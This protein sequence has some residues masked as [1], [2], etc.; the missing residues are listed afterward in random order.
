MMEAFNN[1]VLLITD[2]IFG[3]MLLLPRPVAIVLVAVGTAL[4]L[5][6]LRKWATDQDLLQRC[7]LDKQTLKQRIKAA[8]KEHDH[9]AERRAIADAQDALERHGLELT[10]QE[11]QQLQ[12]I[13]R[14]SG[15]GRVVQRLKGVRARVSA[16]PIRQEGLPLLLAIVPIALLAVWCFM[17]LAYHPPEAGEPV[18]V[19]AHFPLAEQ[20]QLAHLLPQE[21]LSVEDGWIEEIALAKLGGIQYGE[22]RWSVSAEAREEP[23]ELVIRTPT[24]DYQHQ[25]LVGELTYSAPLVILDDR[26]ERAIELRMRE[27][28]LAGIPG[29]G[30]WF[31]PWLIAYLL[32]TIPVVPVL[33]RVLRVA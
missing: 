22:A 24:G 5:T 6:L 23:Y 7:K 15:L 33:R 3:W 2:P 20:G 18:E 19:V 10:D 11:R 27:A 30:A 14:R 8:R 21:G 32:V 9:A 16:K 1:L 28:T 4:I 31:P 12:R 13:A 25:L 17:R 26:G 29:F